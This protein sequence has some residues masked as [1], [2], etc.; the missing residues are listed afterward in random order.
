VDDP[1]VE[2]GDAG[3]ATAVSPAREVTAGPALFPS[4]ARWNSN[5]RMTPTVTD[6]SAML[7]TGQR[8]RW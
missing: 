5:S 7:K 2:P 1:G 3:E 6:A 8:V 4:I